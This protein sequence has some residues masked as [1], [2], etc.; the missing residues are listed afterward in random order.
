M[1]DATLCYDKGGGAY[2]FGNEDGRVDM[3]KKIAMQKQGV[4]F[5]K[6]N[7]EKKQWF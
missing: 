7:N 6:G 3:K 2:S 4:G 1:E 5:Q